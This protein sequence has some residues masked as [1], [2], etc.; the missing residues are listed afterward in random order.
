MAGRP[1]GAKTRERPWWPDA[2][3][4][5]HDGLQVNEIARKLEMDRTTVYRF[6]TSSTGERYYQKYC[7]NYERERELVFKSVAKDIIGTGINAQMLQDSPKAVATYTPTTDF[8]NELVA[9]AWQVY[10]DILT[11][12]EAGKGI[13]Q[14]V[15]S[16]VLR[17]TGQLQDKATMDVNMMQGIVVLNGKH[18]EDQWNRIKKAEEAFDVQDVEEDDDAEASDSV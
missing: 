13:R 1:K 2:V 10:D 7:D 8:L 9:K 18:D 14:K 3:K 17:G 16:D 4:L 5:K 15:A 6:F 12:P 11:D